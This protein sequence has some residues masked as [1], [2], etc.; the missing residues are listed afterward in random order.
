V[1]RAFWLVTGTVVIAW[2]LALLPMPEWIAPFRPEW[3]LLVLAYWVM[4]LP[5]RVGIICCW[6]AGLGL[7]VLYGSILGQHA[8]ALAL[9]GWVVARSHLQVRVYPAWQQALV[10][11]A[12]VIIYEFV[13]FWTDGIAAT[14]ANVRWEPVL[15]TALLWPWVFVVLRAARRR[16]KVA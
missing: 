11:L 2:V 13:L 14:T 12:L 7:D 6:F 5:M 15:T 10:L 9:V 8:L 1:S 16:F 3:T 4:A